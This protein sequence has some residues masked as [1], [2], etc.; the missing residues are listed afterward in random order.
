MITANVLAMELTQ[1]GSFY[2]I[3]RERS[4]SRAAK[5]LGL[6]QPA[7]SLQIKA[8]GLTSS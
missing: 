6:A 7:L 3:A 4:V 5:R 2:A 1:L 8:L